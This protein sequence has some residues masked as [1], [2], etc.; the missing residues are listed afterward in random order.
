MKQEKSGV[1]ALLLLIRFRYLKANSAAYHL[2]WSRLH[3]T[4]LFIF[5]KNKKQKDYARLAKSDA[6][7]RA[8]EIPTKLD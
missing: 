7:T 1:G 5:E 4:T 3:I 8:N 6:I 2:L